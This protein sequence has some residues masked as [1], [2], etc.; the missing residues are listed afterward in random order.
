[1]DFVLVA[2]KLKVITFIPVTWGFEVNEQSLV[3]GYYEAAGSGDRLVIGS[4]SYKIHAKSVKVRSQ[5]KST[6][7]Q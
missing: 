7:N 5:C 1:M 4:Y 2:P 3:K 6:Q